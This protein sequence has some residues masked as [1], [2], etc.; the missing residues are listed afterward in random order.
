MRSGRGHRGRRGP[1]PVVARQP[2]GT[3]AADRPPAAGHHRRAGLVQCQAQEARAA[4]QVRVLRA[5][6]VPGHQPPDGIQVDRSGDVQEEERG[7]RRPVVTVS[8]GHVA[9]TPGRG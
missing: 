6:T 3:A 9:R 5:A 4:P 7:R 1:G 2:Y 8:P